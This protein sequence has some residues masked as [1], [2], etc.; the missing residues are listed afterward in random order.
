[1][2]QNYYASWLSTNE[3]TRDSFLS[4]LIRWAS[5]H[6]VALRFSTSAQHMWRKTLYS[7]ILLSFFSSYGHAG[8]VDVIPCG[9]PWLISWAIVLRMMNI[10]GVLP[11]RKIFIVAYDYA[12]HMQ[13]E[14][15]SEIFND[16]A[17]FR[18][19]TTLYIFWQKHLTKAMI[20]ATTRRIGKKFCILKRSPAHSR[21]D[22]N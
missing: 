15:Q 21:I 9:N 19:T 18:K 2:C 12:R 8:T 11:L 3:C 16:N 7:R 5:R 10:L 22:Y 17:K 1:M 20:I 4:V 14:R 13:G 6:L